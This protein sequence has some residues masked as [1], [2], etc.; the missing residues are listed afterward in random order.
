VILSFIKESFDCI[1]NKNYRQH[2]VQITGADDT[3]A[4][5]LLPLS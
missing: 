2:T 3:D 4:E 1:D 5:F